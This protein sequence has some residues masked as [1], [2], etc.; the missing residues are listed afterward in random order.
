MP[1]A[2]VVM[3]EWLLL[4]QGRGLETSGVQNST[5]SKYPKIIFHSYSSFLQG[6][7]LVQSV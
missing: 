2:K 3:I 5:N 7:E 1:K 6:P 4:A